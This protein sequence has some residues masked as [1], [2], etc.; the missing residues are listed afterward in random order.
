MRYQILCALFLALS[1]LGCQSEEKESF[2]GT[3]ILWDEWGVPHIY[4]DN[5]EDLMY[6]F[7]W[8]QMHNHANLI[9]ELMAGSRG[10]GAQFFGPS[11]VQSDMLVHSLQ[12]PEK[13][14]MYLED[15]SDDMQ[16]I[17]SGFARG[18]NDYAEANPDAIADTHKGILPI[19]EA[20]L[21]GHTL[22]VVGTRFVGGNDLGVVS[23]WEE[24]GSNAYAVA[25]SRT[26]SGNAMLV[27]NP[28]LPWAGEFTW[29]EAHLHGP[30]ANLY[31]ATLVG[32]P[33]LGIAF[34]EHL[35][36]S[37]TNN[38]ID[39]ADTYVLT[40][41]EGGY[42]LDGE[43]VPFDVR[44]KTIQIMQEDGSLA[45]EELTL[46]NSQHGPIVKRGEGQALA[47]RLAGMEDAGLM[48]QWWRM[49][50]A[51]NFSE[52][53]DAI[54]DVQIPFFNIMYADQEGNIFY[55]F[56]GKVPKR[57]EDAWNFWRGV[58]P[59]DSS[60]LIWDEYH[61]YAEL[62]KVKNPEQG[63]LQ[64]ANDP[65]WT[66]TIPMALENDDFPG[67]MAP[68]GMAFRPQR[69]ARMLMEDTSI[70]FEELKTYKLSTRMELADRVLDDLFAAA[71][72][73]SDSLVTEAI[74][75]LQNWDRQGNVDSKGAALF[76]QWSREMSFWNQETFA[77]PWSEENPMTTPDGLSN[78]E[79]AVATL[80][81]VASQMKEGYG[82]LDVAWG[83]FYRIKRGDINLPANGADGSVGI[84]RVTWPGG[85]QDGQYIAG[86]G[87]S[88]VGVI[89]FGEEVQAK[90]LLS[91]GNASQPGSPH[92]GDQ[93]QL[94]SDK[95]FRDAY[96]YREQVDAHVQR[97][98]VMQDSAMV[99]GE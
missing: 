56:N 54:D 17:L 62:P 50:T 6:A 38:T 99:A 34:N 24:L 74:A 10:Q 85:F 40:L 11:K 46:L 9:L 45:E 86:G 1:L 36:W 35:G 82:A 59:G 94:Y 16:A 63:W 84:F 20:D 23:N 81:G 80:A 93:F 37:H 52:F 42:L 7:G 28:H 32:L 96:F 95:T 33:G 89:E 43:T 12:I 67:Y 26:A 49:G 15:Q 39:N 65:P 90:V 48:D 53:E 68:T 31:G 88:W 44:F 8:A 25:P 70:T 71:E 13:A 19:T 30:D 18:L 60:K 3:E 4:S 21:L 27:Q 76:Y 41:Q 51:T 2:S 77:T 55:M 75:V 22:F 61:S 47:L 57:T 5:N 64:N 87:D 91:Y 97:R 98:E 72:G 69:S 78:P 14:A 83:D 66:S 58:V 92:N 79:G 29:M 73:S